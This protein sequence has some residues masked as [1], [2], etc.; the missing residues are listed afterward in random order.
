M[1]PGGNTDITYALCAG[2]DPRLTDYELLLSNIK[3]L[4]DGKDV[5]VCTAFCPTPCT[6]GVRAPHWRYYACLS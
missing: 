5:Q 2:P 3:D 4:K 1:Q 6:P